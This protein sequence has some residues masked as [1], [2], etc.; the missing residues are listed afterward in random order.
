LNQPSKEEL[1]RRQ[2][3]RDSI[4]AA[5]EAAYLAQLELERQQAV[6]D[7]LAAIGE[8]T[9]DSASLEKTFGYFATSATGIEEQFTIENEKI[10]LTF[11]NKGGYVCAA[12]MKNYTR[13]DSLPLMLFNSGEASLGF[14]LLT[15]DNRIINTK[16]LFFKPIIAKTDDAQIVTMRLSA[17]AES[18]IDFVYTIPNN[19]FMTS[20]DIKAHN[21]S[22]YLSP[23]TSSLDVQWQSLIRQNEK[24]RKFESRYA[25]LNYKYVADD[26]EYLSEYKN[27]SEKLS[28]KVR[29]VA[30]KDHFFSSIMIADDA[31][32]ATSVETEI[33]PERSEFIKQHKMEA[34]VAF[35]PTGV[36]S[37]KFHTFYGPN[38]Y[39]V[40]KSYDATF[41]NEE[42]L[43]LQHIIP[44]GWSIFRWISTWVIIPIF[45]FLGKYIGSYGLIIF[46][47]TIIIKLVILPFTFK[48]Y[49]SSAKMRVLRPQID[50]INA[51]IPAEKAMERQQATMALY[52]KA[53]VNPMSGCLPM[54]FQMPILFAMFSFFPTA[55]ELRGQSFLWADDL[56]S[57]D[58]IFSWDTYIPLITPYFGN[59]IS[60]FCLLMTITNI[61]YTKINMATTGAGDQPG[62][63]MMKWMMYLMPIMFMFMFNN[64]AS[65]LSYYYFVSLLITIIQTYLFRLFI[66]DKKVLAQ[67]EK[68]KAKPQKKSGFMQRLEEAQRAQQQALREQQARQMKS[69]SK[70]RH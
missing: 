2:Q 27:D 46:L 17:T 38:Q 6:V 62:A 33:M 13:H 23:N 37:T 68:N 20:M 67:L 58:A 5:N 47:L 51:R 1:A 64:Y 12:E 21:M 34:T 16:N 19:D 50:E 39:R 40:L 18:Y 28:G 65:G 24:G 26:M 42:D 8:A 53:G 3:V 11:S 54:L 69:N 14:T 36:R 7:S 43:N 10:R 60:L 48:S 9:L 66:D 70:G 4:A 31:F 57:Y 45:N 29:W 49:M 59:H 61:I 41:E 15:S 52:Q 25:T 22:Q 63:G 30:F 55:F 44:M 35:D 56:S 32:T